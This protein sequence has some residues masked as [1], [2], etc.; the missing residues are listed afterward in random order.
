MPYLSPCQRHRQV[1]GGWLAAGSA[2]L[3]A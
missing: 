2:P 3:M 1:F